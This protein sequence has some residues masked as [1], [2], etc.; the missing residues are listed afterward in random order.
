[1]RQN[2]QTTYAQTRCILTAQLRYRAQAAE[3][4][5]ARIREDAADRIAAAEARADAA[6][7]RMAAL[8]KA[9]KTERAD[10]SAFIESPDWERDLL[11]LARDRVRAE[12]LNL[13]QSHKSCHQCGSFGRAFSERFLQAEIDALTCAHDLPHLTPLPPADWAV[14]MGS[15]TKQGRGLDNSW[16][17]PEPTPPRRRQAIW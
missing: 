10:L 11:Q 2:P 1:M 7:A 16:H 17:T 14:P 6:E 8:H 3:A 15:V 9:I 12:L 5:T 4:E 13:S